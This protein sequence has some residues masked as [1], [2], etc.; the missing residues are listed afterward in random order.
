M[1]NILIVCADKSLRKDL[2][3]ALASELKCLYL[4]VDELLDFEILNRQEIR[5]SEASKALNQ[6]ELDTL[7]RV[8]EFKNCVITI[9]NQLFVSND[10]F[11]CIT[12]VVK[13]YVELS[14]SYL[15]SKAS[16]KDIHK[17]EQELCVYDEIN[18]LIKSNCDF[19]INKDIK[20]IEQMCQEIIM[21][22]RK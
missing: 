13:V 21:N 15:V 22:Y 16:K 19:C 18:N 17:L 1:K 12:D 9:S 8:A 5:L 2:S 7:K 6:M 20:T 3:R 10:N 4:D 11:E 14:K